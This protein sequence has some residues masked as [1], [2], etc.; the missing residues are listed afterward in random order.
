[1]SYGTPPPPPPPPYG[2]APQGSGEPQR[3][4]LSLI[5]LI[6]GIVGVIPCCW[7]FVVVSIAAIVLG[8]LGLNE[9]KTGAKT[10]KGMAKAG[11]ILGIVGVLLGVLYW[12][13]VATGAIDLDMYT[14]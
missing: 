11:L 1:M 10:G 13:L 12:I 4:T 6:T 9:T 7:G 2:S 5:A 14:S 8:Y 3:S